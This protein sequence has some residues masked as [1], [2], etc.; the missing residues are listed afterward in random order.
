[1]P[2][3]LPPRDVNVEDFEPTSL[4]F[5]TGKLDDLED[6]FAV[7]TALEERGD[8]EGVG[9]DLEVVREATC[10]LPDVPEDETFE[11]PCILED[12]SVFPPEKLF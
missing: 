4:D 1:M 2:P 7:L 12:F 6:A 5:D 11:P 10:L 8:G 3:W 9:T